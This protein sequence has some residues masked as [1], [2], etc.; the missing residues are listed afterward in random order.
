MPATAAQPPVPAYNM[1][2]LFLQ[3]ARMPAAA[4]QPPVPA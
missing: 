3:V 1:L 2:F 4:A